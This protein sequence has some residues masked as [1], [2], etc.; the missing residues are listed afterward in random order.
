MLLSLLVNLVNQNCKT[1]KKGLCFVT[2]DGKCRCFNL[3]ENSGATLR[4]DLP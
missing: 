4:E 2:H 3:L 1:T